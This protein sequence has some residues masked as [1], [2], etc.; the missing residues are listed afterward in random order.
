MNRKPKI[1]QHHPH[2]SEKGIWSK[3]TAS[4]PYVK[5]TL[6]RLLL[7]MS[8]RNT[9]LSVIQMCTS[10]SRIVYGKDTKVYLPINNFYIALKPIVEQG[11]V[12]KDEASL[13]NPQ[14]YRL[15]KQGRSDLDTVLTI[16][17]QFDLEV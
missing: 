17:E 7:L 6:V 10:I 3:P 12:E 4:S 14:V 1:H 2:L 15:T 16:I 8:L 5:W 9:P 11:L 13:A